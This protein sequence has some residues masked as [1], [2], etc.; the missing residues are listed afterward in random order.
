MGRTPPGGMLSKRLSSKEGLG[1]LTGVL[2]GVAGIAVGV[3]FTSVLPIRPSWS[4]L[5][6]PAIDNILPGGF[7]SKRLINKEGGDDLHG[8]LHGV[9]AIPIGFRF[10]SSLHL[11]GSALSR[12]S[13]F[14][15]NEGNDG[16][17]GGGP[18]ST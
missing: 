9:V 17:H 4:V 8:A 13:A 5:L 14:N 11:S 2:D 18:S 1:R 3:S 6:L 7:L 16:L 15:N 10:T 12:N